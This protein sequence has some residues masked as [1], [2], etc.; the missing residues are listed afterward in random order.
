VRRD[1]QTPVHLGRDRIEIDGQPLAPSSKIY[2]ALNKPRGRSDDR[3]RR[4]KPGNRV[5]VFAG[6][7]CP[8]IAPVGRLDKA[9]EGLL[10]LTNDSEWAARITAP[11]THLDKTYHVQIRAIADEVLVHALRSGIRANDGELLCLK[12][13][14]HSSPWRTLFVARNCAGRRQEPAHPANA[15]S[16]ENRSAPAR[17]CGHR[18]AG[19]GRTTEGRNSSARTA[20]EAGVGSR[21]CARAEPRTRFFCSVARPIWFCK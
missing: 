18:A 11:E 16:A 6:G 9:S 14:L 3:G 13:S 2:L 4:K 7:P 1:P 8:W 10:L 17:A 21:R 5:R 15:R 19:A 12:K 20:R